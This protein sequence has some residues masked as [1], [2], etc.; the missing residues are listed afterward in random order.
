MANRVWPY[1]DFTLLQIGLPQ[2]LPLYTKLTGLGD[3]GSPEQSKVA[4]AHF[5]EAISHTHLHCMP[6][7]LREHHTEGDRDDPIWRV[8][9]HAENSLMRDVHRRYLRAK[10]STAEDRKAFSNLWI[11]PTATQQVRSPG[12]L[13]NNWQSFTPRR[14]AWST[15]KIRSY[16]AHR[17]KYS[18]PISSYINNTH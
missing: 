3:T 5:I 17:R 8:I 13:C 12:L 7:S 16:V 11:C 10:N 4:L 18:L 6:R 15:S 1:F 9:A 2:Q 14:G